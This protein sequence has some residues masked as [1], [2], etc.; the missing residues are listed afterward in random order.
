VSHQGAQAFISEH[1]GRVARTH[2]GVKI[3]FNELSRGDARVDLGGFLGRAYNLKA[4]ADF[5]TGPGSVVP[6]DRVEAAIATAKRFVECVTGLLAADGA[7]AKTC[8]R[9]RELA[10]DLRMS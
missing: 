6:L 4:V 3:R 2:D 8:R 9:R 1:A 10:L 7:D 5:E